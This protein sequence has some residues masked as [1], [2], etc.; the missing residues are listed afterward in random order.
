MTRFARAK[1]SKASNERREEDPTPWH[2]MRQQLADQLNNTEAQTSENTT[3]SLKHLLDNTH[4]VKEEVWSD[5]GDVKGKKSSTLK[6]KIK[7]EKSEHCTVKK[8]KKKVMKKNDSDKNDVINN[9][10]TKE[11][12][13]KTKKKTKKVL[14]SIQHEENEKVPIH[15]K[16]EST[17]GSGVLKK[18]KRTASKKKI[19]EG[20]KKFKKTDSSVLKT[21]NMTSDNDRSDKLLDTDNKIKKPNSSKQCKEKNNIILEDN[22]TCKQQKRSLNNSFDSEKETKPYFQNKK[23]HN[24]SHTI[25][26]NGREIKVVDFEG[27]LIKQDDASEL[28][29]LRIKLRKQ[30]VPKEQIKAVMKLE[31][32]KAEKALAREKTNV[33]FHCRKFGHKF[34]DC[35]EIKDTE[36]S[37]SGICFKCGSM[38]HSHFQCKVIQ[39][40]GFRYAVCFVCKEQGHIARQCPLNPQGQYPKGGSCHLCG[41]VT[42][43]RKDCPKATEDNSSNKKV[44]TVEKLKGSNLEEIEEQPSFNKESNMKKTSVVKF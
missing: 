28:K 22:K 44:I 19:N 33:C 34:S 12:Q 15:E 10:E 27:F 11:G 4:G 6:S 43:L 5:F 2:V 13:S 18:R 42:H 29:K 23:Y 17:D 39:S 37:K 7:K 20:G 35:P 26:A 9:N 32:R 30:N 8:I 38:E 40:Q 36:L 16:N 21:D 24:N 25:I 14:K 41:E 3:Y 31:R 1:G